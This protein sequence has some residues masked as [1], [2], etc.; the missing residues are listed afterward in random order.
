MGLFAWLAQKFSTVLEDMYPSV[1]MGVVIFWGGGLFV[2]YQ[3]PSITSEWT[4][5][6]FF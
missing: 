2:M 5:S 3:A 4:W 6:V 1:T